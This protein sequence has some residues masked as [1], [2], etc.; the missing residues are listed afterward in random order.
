ME[1]IAASL[2]DIYEMLL[3]QGRPSATPTGMCKY[4]TPEGLRCAVGMCVPFSAYDGSM[5]EKPLSSSFVRKVL[6]RSHCQIP[7]EDLEL[8][9]HCHD[10]ATQFAIVH[11]PDTGRAIGLDL[12]EWKE[13]FKKLWETRVVRRGPLG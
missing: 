11:D 10:Q 8:A 3:E 13:Y 7:L 2:Q 5:E 4:R 6:E 12:G 1:R 9:Q